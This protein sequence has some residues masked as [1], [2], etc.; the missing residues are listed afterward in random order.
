MAVRKPTLTKGQIRKR[1]A[2]RKSVGDKLGD[3]TFAR[4]MKEQAKAKS[5]AKSDPVA[6]KILAA[7]KPLVRDKTIKL[8]NKGY[9]V[10]RAKGKGA[11][12]FV[13]SKITK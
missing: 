6:D 11:K 4:W 13:V 10:R 12:G 5:V 8:G 9:S 2:L 7:L 1:N 3:Q